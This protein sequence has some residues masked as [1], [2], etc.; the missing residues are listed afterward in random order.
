MD[1]QAPLS[2]KV[3][4]QE[5]WKGFPFP[6]PGDLPHLGIKPVSLVSSVSAGRFFT[7]TSP[8]KVPPHQKK[9][10]HEETI[11]INFKGLTDSQYTEY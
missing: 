5:Y 9:K 11:R 10:K 8:G 2:V 4:R 1:C 3:S 7:A 6:T